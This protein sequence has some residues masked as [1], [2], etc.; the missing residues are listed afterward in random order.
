M[1]FCLIGNDGLEFSLIGDDG[2]SIGIESP[3]YIDTPIYDGETT[4]IPEFDS[5]VLETAHKL[6]TGDITVEPIQ[7]ERTSNLSGG[8]TVYI[9]GII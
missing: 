1:E 8:V 3:T 2:I 9:G 5:I 6:V 7:V 4:I